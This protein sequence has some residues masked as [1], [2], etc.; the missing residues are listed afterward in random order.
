MRI[1]MKNNNHVTICGWMINEL[2]LTGNELL[3]YAL[4]YGFSQDGEST[5]SGSRK[6]ISELIGAKSL[7]TVDKYLQTLLEK[8]LITK[9]SETHNGVITNHYKATSEHL[10]FK[11]CATP[12]KNEYPCSKNEHDNNSNIY[13]VKEERDKSLSKKGQKDELFEQCWKEYRRKGSK[14]KAKVQ[15]DKLINDEKNKV[16]THI[17]AYVSSRDLQY[18]KDFE[19]YLKDKIFNTLV[20]ANNNI[21]YDPTLF[22]T[23]EYRPTLTSQ[24]LFHNE[25]KCYLYIGY[26]NGFI[27]DGYEDDNRPDGATIMLN[28][29]RGIVIWNKE[30]KQWIL[31][32]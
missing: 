24:L 10:F 3:C 23:N 32:R 14:A 31:Q 4:I 9:T 5:F 1:D 12:S 21:L 29:G 30:Q 16:I 7:N 11:D 6:Y 2:G 13:S 19:R 25:M 27:G 28:N 26:F 17:K 20:I 15:W 8:G 18:Q 22:D